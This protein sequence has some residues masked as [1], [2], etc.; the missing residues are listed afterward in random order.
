MGVRPRRGPLV[1]NLRELVGPYAEPGREVRTARIDKG[2]TQEELADIVGT[3]KSA[4][5]RLES[6]QHAPMWHTI[7]RVATALGKRISIKFIDSRNTTPQAMHPPHQRRQRKR[8][9]R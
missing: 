2:L 1:R 5:C 6:G 4:I 3:S 7:E 8:A 9:L